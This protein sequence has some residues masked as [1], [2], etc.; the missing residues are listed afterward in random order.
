MK[1]LIFVSI[2]MLFL[3]LFINA[4]GIINKEINNYLAKSTYTMQELNSKLL[5]QYGVN[6]IKFVQLENGKYIPVNVSEVN[7]ISEGKIVSEAQISSDVII[8]FAII[9]AVLVALILLRS[10]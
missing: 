5:D 2:L 8:I 3:P 9:G 6:N 7:K 4:Q 10:I 1:R